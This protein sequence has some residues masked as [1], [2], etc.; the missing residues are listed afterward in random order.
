MITNRTNN[1]LSADSSDNSVAKLDWALLLIRTVAGVIFMA[2]GAQKL[3]G[4]FDGPGLEAIVKG[5]GPVGYLVAI[6]EFFGGLGLAIGFLSR[7]SAFW[8]AVIM[9]GAVVKVHGKSGFFLSQQG[10]E[11]NLALIGLLGAVLILGPGRLAVSEWLP[12]LFH[13]H[14]GSKQALA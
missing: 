12:R 5:M 4:A 13:R 9:V 6:G 2:H 11:Y 14:A 1:E 7:F 3:F 10:F 8:L